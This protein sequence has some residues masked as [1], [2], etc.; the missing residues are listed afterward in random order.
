MTSPFCVPPNVCFNCGQ[1]GHMR[2]QCPL[3]LQK[4]RVSVT[5]PVS[6]FAGVCRRCEK[7]GHKANECRSCFKKDGTPLQ[8]NVMSCVGGA[9]TQISN[10]QPAQLQ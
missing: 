8:G 2:K 1:Q 3:R 5:S 6:S 4:Q 9:A 7:F 10:P